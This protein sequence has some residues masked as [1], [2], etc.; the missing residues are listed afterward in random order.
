MREADQALF[1]LVNVGRVVQLFRQQLCGKEQP[2]L[3]LLSI[4]AGAVEHSL[5]ASRAT[6]PKL[7][8]DS[9]SDDE[10]EVE[11]TADVCNLKLEPAI[12]YVQVSALYQ[13]YIAVIKG[14]CDLSLFPDAGEF[15]TKDLI[16][17]VSDILWNTLS[18]DK[19]KDRTHISN[20]FSYVT[21]SKLDCFGVA[22]GVVAGCQVLGFNDVHLG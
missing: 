13:K 7:Q 2:D 20:I 22:F 19:I 4:V 3:V 18:K 14:Y 16:K 5:T 12:S 6:S 9:G 1:P 21:E 17:R 15:A 8:K 10:Y 11:E